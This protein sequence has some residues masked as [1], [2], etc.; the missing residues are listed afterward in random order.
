M[1]AKQED[2]LT[3][4]IVI[5][6]FLD[7]TAPE[8]LDKMPHILSVKAAYNANV[9]ILR[10]LKNGQNL[11]RTGIRMTKDT[12]RTDM[13]NKAFEIAARTCAYA[14][15]IEDPE[16]E[17]TVT[18]VDS[19]FYNMRDTAVA[20]ACTSILT[21]ATQ[22]QVP[23]ELYGVTTTTL[24]QLQEAITLYNEV[25]PKTRAGIVNRSSFTARIVE[26][27]K[28]NDKIAYRLDKLVTILRFSHPEFYTTYF[29]S[30][31]IINTGSRK[32]PLR[33]TITNEFGK[34][35]LK[36]TVTVEAT[37]HIQTKTTEKGN[38]TFKSLPAGVW[39][40]TFH[41]VGYTPQKVFLVITPNQRTDY[42]VTLNTEQHQQ[43]SA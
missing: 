32:I 40:V 12:L 16:L 10:S 39:P 13:T 1:T 35:L 19:D 7:H 23:L 37:K 38:Y 21:I 41:R 27:F 6:D 24:A 14:L 20:D 26:V 4:E 8:I 36:V 28:Q 9:Q 34:P 43:S 33:G 29:K 2:K 17:K 22:Q 15:E 42:N 11:N 25:L 3:M 31:K 30:R 18:Y 5:G